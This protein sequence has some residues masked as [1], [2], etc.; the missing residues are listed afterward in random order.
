MPKGVFSP[1]VYMK[2][3][4][5]PGGKKAE[6]GIDYTVFSYIGCAVYIPLVRCVD[7]WRVVVV[8]DPLH[9]VVDVHI[10]IEVRRAVDGHVGNAVTA[11]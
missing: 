6:R 2:Y 1:Y 4:R 11:T 10:L 5:T 9:L 7:Q 8:L 3:L